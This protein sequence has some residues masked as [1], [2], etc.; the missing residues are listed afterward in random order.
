MAV[1]ICLD[2]GKGSRDC[3]IPQVFK[4]G[5]NDIVFHYRLEDKGIQGKVVIFIVSDELLEAVG[6][7]NLTQF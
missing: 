6:I 3:A 4:H 5:G 1:V 7:R 2:G